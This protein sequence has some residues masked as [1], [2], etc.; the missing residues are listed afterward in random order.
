MLVWWG[1]K[2]YHISQPQELSWDANNMVEWKS[3]ARAETLIIRG[4]EDGDGLYLDPC[5]NRSL[6]YI[7]MLSWSEDWILP[8][9]YI[10]L[11]MMKS[12][13]T[14][15]LCSK[16]GVFLFYFH[17]YILDYNITK[18]TN[19][20]ILKLLGKSKLFFRILVNLIETL[21]N[22]LVWILFLVRHIVGLRSYF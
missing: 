11:I 12:L 1:N 8:C 20:K 10:R 13:S 22:V 18:I 4:L 16:I 3:E 17:C 9:S 7:W 15:F 19:L 21:C 2:I 14:L 6:F 5:A